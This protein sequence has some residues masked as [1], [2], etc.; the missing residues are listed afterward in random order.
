MNVIYGACVYVYYLV[1]PAP[2]RQKKL[3][4]TYRILCASAV[5]AIC[6][7]IHTSHRQWLQYNPERL[8]VQIKI[9]FSNLIFFTTP[10][11]P[12]LTSTSLNGNGFTIL[13]EQK[14][15]KSVT[16]NKITISATTLGASY[17]FFFVLLTHRH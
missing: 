13:C 12:C 11:V 9:C 7:T 2:T 4:C 14:K 16:K 1:Q 5:T 10:V 17:L 3:M 6:H 8:C 15:K